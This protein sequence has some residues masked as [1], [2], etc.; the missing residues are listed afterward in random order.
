MAKITA[1]QIAAMHPFRAAVY[2][3]PIGPLQTYYTGTTDRI[4]AVKRMTDRA[5][6]EAA[7]AVPEL[8]KTV[9]AAISRRLKQLDQA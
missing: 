1:E 4:A 5:Q 9:A 8:Q 3:T 6:L 2:D 7:A